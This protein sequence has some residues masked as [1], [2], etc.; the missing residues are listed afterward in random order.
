VLI[1][2]AP[3]RSDT[4]DGSGT[5]AASAAPPACPPASKELP[6]ANVIA[7]DAKRLFMRGIAYLPH[8]LFGKF[9]TKSQP[10]SGAP[11]Q[12][13]TPLIHRPDGYLSGQVCNR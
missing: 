4:T 6:N 9:E 1:T 2:A 10:H 7:I 3:A 13:K 11:L 12:F 5:A 8:A